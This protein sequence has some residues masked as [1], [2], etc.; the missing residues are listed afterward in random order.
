[1][2]SSR[3]TRYARRNPMPE[4]VR[5]DEIVVILS[6]D[7]EVET[8]QQWNLFAAL[9]SSRGGIPAREIDGS[10][11]S[12]ADVPSRPCDSRPSISIPK[13]RSTTMT[14][15]IVREATAI[16]ELSRQEM[17]RVQGGTFDNSR[18]T[19]VARAIGDI[20]IN[21]VGASRVGGGLGEDLLIGGTVK[22]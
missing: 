17:Q 19:H 2:F 22:H 8:E 7:R 14:G 15:L 16:T 13:T 18:G 3:T 5:V 12:P 1:M 6:A 20:G 10:R 9:L 21:T 11:I 4:I